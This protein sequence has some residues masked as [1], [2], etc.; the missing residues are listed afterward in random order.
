MAK[1]AM[2]DFI[3]PQGLTKIGDTQWQESIDS[4]EARPQQANVGTAGS[5]K[6][7]NLEQ[8]NVDLT[9]SLVDLIVAQRTYQANCQSLQT[10]NTMMD[11]IMSVR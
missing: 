8:S 2:A 5:I 7:A 4:G 3:N 9:A 1:V 6:G 10:E 11:A